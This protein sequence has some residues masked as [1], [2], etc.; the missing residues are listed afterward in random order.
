MSQWENTRFSA[1][2]R[3]QIWSNCQISPLFP[4]KLFFFFL[5]VQNPQF[6][7]QNFRLEIF[8]NNKFWWRRWSLECLAINL[9]YRVTWLENFLIRIDSRRNL[10]IIKKYL[11]GPKLR[12]WK[13][14]KPWEKF[15]NKQKHKFSK[16]RTKNLKFI[17]FS[18]NIWDTR[19]T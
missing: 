7:C 14:R 12:C 4:P 19:W 10:L 1:N 15:Q 17:N 18:L 16:I 5:F 11:N 3:Y 13:F 9:P 6:Y 8:Y 2:P